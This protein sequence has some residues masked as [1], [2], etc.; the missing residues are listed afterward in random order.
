MGQQNNFVNSI[1]LV[2]Q[3]LQTEA[4]SRSKASKRYESVNRS[5]LENK[6]F[7]KSENEI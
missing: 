6:S 1:K 5:D 7:Q 2:N 3:R 4:L